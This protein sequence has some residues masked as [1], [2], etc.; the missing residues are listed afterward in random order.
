MQTGGPDLNGVVVHGL[1]DDQENRVVSSKHLLPLEA[2]VDGLKPTVQEPRINQA[3]LSLSDNMHMQMMCVSQCPQ[4]MAPYP[5][6]WQRVSSAEMMRCSL[7][8]FAMR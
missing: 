7:F 3:S 2:R 1:E 5:A 8:W 6:S 4:R